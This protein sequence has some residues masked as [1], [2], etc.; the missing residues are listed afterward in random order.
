VTSEV[1]RSAPGFAVPRGACDCHVHVFGPVSRFPYAAKRSYTPFDAPAAALIELLR[2][3]RLE[4]VVL[5]QPSVYGSDNAA[6]LDAARQIGAGARVVAVIAETTSAAELEHLHRGGTRGVR[7][8]LVMDGIADPGAARR[9]L[10]ET[11][12]R[13]APYGWHIQLLA[14]LPMIAA[15]R[16]DLAA[17][18]VP[19]A[20]DHFGGAVAAGGTTQPG[21]EAL[22]ALV[23]AGRAYVKISAPYRS[24]TAGPDY[25]DVAPLARALIAANPDRILWGTDWPHPGGNRSAA[26]GLD[27]PDP[28][29]PED[30]G[31]TLTLLADWAPDPAV[32][33]KILVDNPARLYG[34]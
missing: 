14:Q 16:D 19:L 34:F 26:R 28:F 11:A 25:A 6:H 1:K 2:D 18:P 9:V 12:A 23:H 20:I 32:R 8:N 17:L 7:V 30:D 4:R 13:I 22:H 21:F 3:L 5:V 10:A 24:S 33:Q 27:E 31:H 15:L 29:F